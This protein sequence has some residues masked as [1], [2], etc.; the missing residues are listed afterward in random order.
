MKLI[1]ACYERGLLRPIKPLPLRPGE[2]VDLIVVRRCDPGRWNLDRIAKTMTTEDLD[3]AEQ[4]LTDWSASE[5]D[6]GLSG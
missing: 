1:E 5:P 2:R 6:T 4:G 3:L